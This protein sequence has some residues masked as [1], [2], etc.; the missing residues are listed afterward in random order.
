MASYASYSHHDQVKAR[1]ARIVETLI[2]ELAS[3][4]DETGNLDKLSHLHDI[5]DEIDDGEFL[6]GEDVNV[7]DE[8]LRVMIENRVEQKM[9]ENHQEDVAIGKERARRMSYQAQLKW[10]SR[11][12]PSNRKKESQTSPGRKEKK[13]KK[14]SRLRQTT[15]RRLP[16]TMEKE[17]RGRG[18]KREQGSKQR[19]DSKGDSG[20][21]ITHDS[22]AAQKREIEELKKTLAS[23]SASDDGAAPVSS[24]QKLEKS[25][26]VPGLSDDGPDILSNAQKTK[27][28]VDMLEKIK[29]EVKY[30]IRNSPTP[31]E[32]TGWFGLGCCAGT[33]REDS[34]DDL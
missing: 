26:S 30:K 4:A 11:G 13:T 7:S 20:S 18:R 6:S 9:L 8:N 28:E 33:N 22:I 24:E 10:G 1:S 29:N 16:Q 23:V 15:D 5:E 25:A 12:T 27:I 21:S 19:K 34:D 32:S 14:T 31:Q 2:D 17:G 3:L